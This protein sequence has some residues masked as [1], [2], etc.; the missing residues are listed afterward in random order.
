M[1]ENLFFK[2]CILKEFD[3]VSEIITGILSDKTMENKSPF[4][5][6]NITLYRLKL[7]IE[8]LPLVWTNLS[9]CNN[10]FWANN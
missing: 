1:G 9:K 2:I 5:I 8:S 10:K 3:G 7:L 6:N 4:I